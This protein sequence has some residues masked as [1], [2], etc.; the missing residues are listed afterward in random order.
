MSDALTP[1]P[2]TSGLIRSAADINAKL[3]EWR[4][5]FHVLSPFTQ[6]GGSFG[7]GIV[8]TV[9]SVSL[10]PRVNEYG[11]GVDTYYSKAFMKAPDGVHAPTAQRAP[12]KVGLLR[13]AQCAGVRWDASRCLRT[14]DGRTPL[15]WSFSA[16]GEYLTP[17]GLWLPLT[18][19]CEVDLRDGSPQ[20]KAM[21]EKQLAVQ[22]QFGLALAES[23]AKNR[24]IRSLGL[25]S[26]YTVEELIKKPF[27]VLRA[28]FQP[29]KDDEIGR[30]VFAQVAMGAS[31]FLYPQAGGAAPALTSAP[32]LDA[33]D[34]TVAPN[35]VID[36]EP[37][38]AV[39]AQVVETKAAPAAPAP[40][41]LTI[42]QTEIKTVRRMVK[43][44]PVEEPRYLVADSQG[45]E[46]V[47]SKAIFEAAQRLQAA[48]TPVDLVTSTNAAGTSVIE[49]IMPDASG[50]AKY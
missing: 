18:G 27:L 48:K 3:K 45:V 50:D 46:H 25:Q 1:S 44:Q 11:Q 30:R 38:K 20:A 19:T 26:A 7:P 4:E 14:D 13:I 21:T 33:P 23:K 40:P 35:G 41:P 16:S 6:M 12:N 2:Q 32:T 49:E 17:D 8:L 29:D 36:I 24:A 9:S 47:A 43:G 5:K 37:T 42:V 22:R 28:T 10:D 31:Q 34:P 39:E 15:Y